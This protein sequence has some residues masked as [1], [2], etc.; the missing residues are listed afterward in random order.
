MLLLV[1]TTMKLVRSLQVSPPNFAHLATL[2]QLV[3]FQCSPCPALLANTRALLARPHV[4][5]VPQASTAWAQQPSRFLAPL[6]TI[7]CRAPKCQWHA[8]LAI[9]VPILCL[10]LKLTAPSAPKE[11]T[12]LSPVFKLLPAFAMLVF[13]VTRAASYLKRTTA[14][15]VLIVK[16]AA[17]RVR[18]VPPATTTTTLT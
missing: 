5:P 8:L 12:V 18:T 16:S 7:V 14:P 10:P 2:A 6:A 1:S 4:I 9:L 3:A 13:T 17:S 15:P 11:A